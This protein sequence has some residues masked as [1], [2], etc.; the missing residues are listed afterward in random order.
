MLPET[1]FIVRVDY[2]EIGECRFL[3][4]TGAL[5]AEYAA[6]RTFRSRRDAERAARTLGGN[7][8]V[9]SNRE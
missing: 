8:T 4:H 3:T 9:E 7:A 5:S 2:P 1:Y 6:A